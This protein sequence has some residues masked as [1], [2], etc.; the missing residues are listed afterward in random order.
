MK[1]ANS[2]SYRHFAQDMTL[3][4]CSQGQAAQKVFLEL[5]W[6]AMGI[7]IRQKSILV[8]V[9]KMVKSRVS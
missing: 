7:G 9:K 6:T 5:L 8:M 3:W 2:D 4:E 1:I